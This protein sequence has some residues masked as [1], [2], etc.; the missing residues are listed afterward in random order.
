M[1]P[2]AKETTLKIINFLCETVSLL[3]HGGIIMRVF[4][5]KVMVIML[6][7][8]YGMALGGWR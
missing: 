3:F 6:L 1:E 5:K 7:V 2:K 4:R 8:F